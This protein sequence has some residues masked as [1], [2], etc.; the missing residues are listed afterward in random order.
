LDFNPSKPL[1]S[2]SP[3]EEKIEVPLFGNLVHNNTTVDCH[4]EVRS[5]AT[6]VTSRFARHE[7]VSFT[8]VA[9]LRSIELSPEKQRE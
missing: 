6:S 5:T 3:V 4:A 8:R 9:T 1:N 7:I 2:F